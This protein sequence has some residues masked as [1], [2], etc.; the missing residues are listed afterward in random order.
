MKL[1]KTLAVAGLLTSAVPAL[2]QDYGAMPCEDLWY[3]RNAIYKEAGYCFKTARA[4][5][6][7]GN[8]GCLYD[9][10][11]AVPLSANARRDVADIQYWERRR[12]CP[13]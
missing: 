6:A 9:D 5:R 13:R 11:G 10:M 4:I 8:A 1:T 12:G 7:F 2:A 3:S